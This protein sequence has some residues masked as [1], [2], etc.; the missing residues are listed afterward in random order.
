MIKILREKQCKPNAMS[1]L[2]WPRRSLF[3]TK[4]VQTERY[5]LARMAEAQPVFNKNSANR[6]L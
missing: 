1:L 5:E 4:T 3:S 2:G 6:T